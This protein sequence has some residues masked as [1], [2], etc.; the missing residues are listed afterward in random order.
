MG[1]VRAVA[2]RGGGGKLVG[3]TPPLLFFLGLAAGCGRASEGQEEGGRDAELEAR[4]EELLPTVAEL[5]HLPVRRVPAVRRASAA[6]LEAYLLARMAAEYPGDSLAHLTQ[7]YQAFGLL[8]DTV[9]LRELLVE[10]MLE[11]AIGFYDPGRNT[12]FVREE[13]PP[14]ALDA[15][16]VHELTH[17]L[18]D[19]QVD[20]DSLI[21]GKG[22]ND[23][24]SAAQS[25]LE[26]HATVT[27]LAYQLTQATGRAVAVEEL[28][29]LGPEMAAMLAGSASMPRLA[30]APAIVRDPLLFTYL[31]GARYV[32]R[33]WRAYPE[34]PPPLGEWLPESTEQLLHTERLLEQR[35]RP[36]SLAIAEPSGDWRVVWAH[37]L[38]ELEIR[39]YFE[40][41]L[42]DSELAERAAAGWDADAYVLLSDGEERVLVWYTLWDSE[43][44][45][46]EFEAAYRQ[47]FEARFGG[48]GSDLELHGPRR[49]ARVERSAIS[50][51]P[52]VGV[53]E[54]R[55]GVEFRLV[56]EARLVRN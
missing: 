12:F 34:R 23:G 51:I 28:P 9:D 1:G 44:D 7:A 49:R 42:G 27:M 39:I 30:Q 55:P 54:A 20:L 46:D 31:G 35:D 43:A 38:G 5:S 3:L 40:E 15:V 22:S 14:A 4:V 25:A 18:Q 8:P 33:L 26:G 10:L 52:L 2:P 6:T 48:G 21:R 47:A 13:A 16:L 11:Q 29:E 53:V 36:R 45:A 41:H 24:R 50:G 56:P 19:Q 37:D 32:Q 17:A